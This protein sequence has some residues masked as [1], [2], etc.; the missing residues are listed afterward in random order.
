MFLE[1]KR[2]KKGQVAVFVIIALVIVFAILFFFFIR[3]PVSIEIEEEFSVDSF[4]K[5]CIDDAVQQA[6]AIM[7]PQGGYIEP[8]NYKLYRDNKV[9]YLCYTNQYYKPCVNQEP[10]YLN[11]IENEISRFI[12]P[13]INECFFQLEQELRRRKYSFEQETGG[14][15]IKLEEGRIIVDVD[16]GVTYSKDSVQ[17]I[18][19]FS[20]KFATRVYD[21]VKVAREIA[22]QEAQFCTFNVASYT[23][24]Y[25]DFSIE[26]KNIGFRETSSSVYIIKDKRTQEELFIAI[27]SCE[28][29]P[30]LLG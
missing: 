27:R 30:G 2:G 21:L 22:N 15:E 16:R 23:T 13:K 18:D 24:T 6:L 29:P 14:T 7:L 26:E 3:R 5:T 4:V 11:H 20:F 12:T 10:L 17:T 25:P 9:E 8:D 28:I 19:S 1:V